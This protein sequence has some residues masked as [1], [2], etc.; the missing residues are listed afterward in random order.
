MWRGWKVLMPLVLLV[1]SV[2]VMAAMV[3]AGLALMTNSQQND[4][5]NVGKRSLSQ[6]INQ[7]RNCI[8]RELPI[9][10]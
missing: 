5:I 2:L 9:C 8:T 7:L 1:L 10:N 6:Q 3:M 4:N